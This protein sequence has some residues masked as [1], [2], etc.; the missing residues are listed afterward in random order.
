MAFVHATIIE[1]NAV[2]VAGCRITLQILV[3]TRARARA[4]IDSQA[5]RGVKNLFPQSGMCNVRRGK[6]EI[7]RHW[8]VDCLYLA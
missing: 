2:S 7:G 5:H 1:L 6:G 3:I 4:L 8:R